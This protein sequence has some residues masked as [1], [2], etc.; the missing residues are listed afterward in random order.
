MFCKKKQKEQVDLLCSIQKLDVKD[1]DVIVLMTDRVLS[2]VTV[3]N[4]KGAVKESLKKSGFDV[5]VLI[6]EEGL[7]IG[8][9]RGK[10]GHY[11]NTR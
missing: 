6:L 2:K 1:G 7:K 4:I 9:L 10:N 11:D 8:I 3:E 5:N